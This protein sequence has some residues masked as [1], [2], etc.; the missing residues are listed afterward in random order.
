LNVFYGCF[1]LFPVVFVLFWFSRFA[2]CG[3]PFLFVQHWPYSMCACIFF[4]FVPCQS[5]S[6]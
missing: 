4:V 3:I 5:G 2:F 6:Y 1:V